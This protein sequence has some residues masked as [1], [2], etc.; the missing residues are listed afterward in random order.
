MG[1]VHLLTD[2]VLERPVA[3]KILK[4]EATTAATQERFRREARTLARLQHPNVVRILDTGERDGFPYIIMEFLEG[5]TLR[6][7]LDA[8]ERLSIEQV[9]TLG[10]ELLDAL[11]PAHAAGIVH[12]D[13]KPANIFFAGGTARLVDFGIASEP[14]LEGDSLTQTGQLL[15][16]HDYMAPEQRAGRPVDG[17]ADL[18][19]LALVLFE[20]LTGHLPAPLRALPRKRVSR[21][22]TAVLQRALAPEPADRWPDAASFRA[23]LLRPAR[24]AGGRRTLA[25]LA[26]AALG[27][28]IWTA[29]DPPVPTSALPRSD[30]LAVLPLDDGGDGDLGRNLTRRVVDILEPFPL[31]RVSPASVTEEWLARRGGIIGTATPLAPGARRRGLACQA[32]QAPRRTGVRERSVPSHRPRRHQPVLRWQ[33]C[34]PARCVGGGGSPP[35]EV[36]DAV[37]ELEWHHWLSSDGR[38]YSFVARLGQRVVGAEMLTPGQRRRVIARVRGDDPERGAEGT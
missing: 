14:T 38:G 13:L 6:Q 15:G 9:P 16:T 7:R 12:R 33:G 30:D 35:G 22:L 17:R 36:E 23:A 1:I 24:F 20:S 28:A 34:L 29:L 27:L 37:D 10:L 25:L 11:V 5:S 32:A 19:S 2:T 3:I 31:L 4:P 26:V 18:Y 21:S 8:G